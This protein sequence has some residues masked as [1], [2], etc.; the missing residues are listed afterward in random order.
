MMSSQHDLERV[1]EHI[2]STC[3]ERLSD[4]L[5]AMST[6]GHQ[7]VMAPKSQPRCRAPRARRWSVNDEQVHNPLRSGWW[8]EP[9]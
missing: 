6:A 2:R 9:L 5:T 3:L 8:F 4:S 1:G 7:C